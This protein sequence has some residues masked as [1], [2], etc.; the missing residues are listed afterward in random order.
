MKIINIKKSIVSLSL[1]V[2]TIITGLGLTNNVKAVSCENS[3]AQEIT[4][5]Y[6][7]ENKD[8]KILESYIINYYVNPQEDIKIPTVSE[9]F[10]FT[11][12][13]YNAIYNSEKNREN[14]YSDAEILKAAL[15][16]AKEYF[17]AL[18]FVENGSLDIN[19]PFNIGENIYDIIPILNASPNATEEEIQKAQIFKNILYSSANFYKNIYPVVKDGELR[20]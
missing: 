12:Y 3:N 7:N 19:I 17:Y 20:R 9:Y 4:S 8:D 6:I 14:P 1:V 11:S 18:S 15:L 2:S 5:T 13:I 16:Y 10:D